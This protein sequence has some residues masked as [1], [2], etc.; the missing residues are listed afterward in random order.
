MAQL[1]FLFRIVL[2]I[3]AM[4]FARSSFNFTAR[5][6]R[7][8]PPGWNDTFGVLLRTFLYLFLTH[9]QGMNILYISSFSHVHSVFAVMRNH[10]GK[11]DLRAIFGGTSRKNLQRKD[12]KEFYLLLV[13][14]CYLYG[15]SSIICGSF[16]NSNFW[17]KLTDFSW[18]RRGKKVF[19]KLMH[20]LTQWN[21]NDYRATRYFERTNSIIEQHFGRTLSDTFPI[22]GRMSNY[23]R[24]TI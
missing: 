18:L 10:K 7:K 12:E 24:A 4:S 22:V 21:L 3:N 9:S 5:K 16:C 13:T 2:G 1:K 11:G 15:Y 14:S 8:P 6:A 19:S 17:H 20:N 23:Y